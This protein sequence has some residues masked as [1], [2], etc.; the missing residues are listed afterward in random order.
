MFL[1]IH[2]SVGI[3]WLMKSGITIDALSDTMYEISNPYSDWIHLLT[4]GMF[5]RL[6]R[7]PEKGSEGWTEETVGCP[8]AYTAMVSILKYIQLYGLTTTTRTEGNRRIL[9]SLH[10]LPNIFPSTTDPLHRSKS[11]GFATDWIELSRSG[12]CQ[13]SG[14]IFLEEK[15]IDVLPVHVFCLLFLFPLLLYDF[16]A[17][18][19][20]SPSCDVCWKNNV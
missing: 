14:C 20:S 1:G 3:L 13:S 7:T 5:K 17:G 18:Q 15:E 10:G 19:L 8:S 11:L 16:W 2:I 9:S 12:Q 4:L 6:W